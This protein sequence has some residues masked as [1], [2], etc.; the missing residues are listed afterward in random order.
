MEKRRGTS[1]I[2]LSGGRS[3]SQEQDEDQESLQNVW[4]S[5]VK[6]DDSSG[7]AD[8]TRKVS[9]TSMDQNSLMS[10]LHEAASQD[11]DDADVVEPKNQ[12]PEEAADIGR[13]PKIVLETAADVQS[14][15]LSNAADFRGQ[16][17]WRGK[18]PKG[19]HLRKENR[20]LRKSLLK[21]S[22]ARSER[23]ESVEDQ[24]PE[25]YEPGSIIKRLPGR[26]RAPHP[27][28]DIE[29]DLRR[30]LE[31]RIAFRNVTR[32][33]KVVLAEL[34]RRTVNDLE[35]NAELH[36]QYPEYYDVCSKLDEKLE[37][38]L[39]VLHRE[40]TQENSR[41]HRVYE[42][43]AYE[44]EAGYEV[45]VQTASHNLDKQVVDLLKQFFCDKQDDHILELKHRFLNLVRSAEK[46]NDS[47]ATDDEV[48][49][50]R[51]KRY[52]LERLMPFV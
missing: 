9:D 3:D 1:N 24:D 15:P 5:R 14:A 34:A 35:S 51:A 17:A 36:T 20:H 38:R 49:I 37:E 21:G 33:H 29:A 28:P 26:K 39:K 27:D 43:S 6:R 7:D 42:A 19:W 30:Q 23:Q 4:S 12:L 11:I 25:K 52:F 18:K 48:R 31:L 46:D 40:F 16:K 41:L 44:C 13:S 47:E 50:I 8:D 45:S 32:A 2:S 22:P 10:E